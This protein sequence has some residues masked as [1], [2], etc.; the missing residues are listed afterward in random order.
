MPASRSRPKR[1]T[2][3]PCVVCGWAEHMAIHQPIISGPRKGQYF[4][5]AYVHPKYD[6]KPP[7][8][9]SLFKQ[10][11]WFL[12]DYAALWYEV[13]PHEGAEEERETDERC[14]EMRDLARRLDR[15]CVG[16]EAKQQEG[17]ASTAAAIVIDMLREGGI[18]GAVWYYPVTKR[19][20]VAG[21]GYEAQPGETCVGVYAP[22]VTHARLAD[23]F[24]RVLLAPYT[25]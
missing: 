2:V 4:G 6:D 12:R 23:D 8:A 9:G 18:P 13:G 17:A 14:E 1:D 24:E 15:L 21:E 5:H 11:A 3:N 10:A 19:W 22:T 25:K 20:R 16:W 7:R